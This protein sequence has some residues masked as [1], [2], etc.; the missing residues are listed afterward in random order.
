MLTP[1]IYEQVINKL[2]NSQLNTEENIVKTEQIDKEEA[3]KILSKYFSEILEKGL[4]NLKD[5]GGDLSKQIE[6]CNKLVNIIA[7]ET[8]ETFINDL[9]VDERAEQ[10]MAYMEKK[11]TIHALNGN[12]EITRPV[13]SIARSSL[14]T[15][16][17]KEPSMFSELK[18]E[19]LSC[20]RMDMLVSFIKWSGLR[21]IIDELKTFVQKGKLRIITTSYMGATDPKAIQELSELPNTEIK[22]SY[23]TKRTRLHAKTYVFYRNSGF[24]TAYIG[25]SNLS[26]A[27][28]S[29]G[30]EW[31]VKATQKDLPETIRKVEATFESYWN[32]SEFIE[33]NPKEKQRLETAIKEERGHLIMLLASILILSPTRIKVRFWTSS[34]LKETLKTIGEISSWQQPGQE[35]LLYRPLIIKIIFMKTSLNHADFCLLRIGKKY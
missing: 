13:T 27:A 3:S 11:N 16:A 2:I 21:L 24:T 25:S 8:E 5:S 30:L 15:G 10:L 1:G 35:K 26:N 6:L 28:I 7:N 31:N 33:Y 12:T 18:K 22:I 19:I 14:F 34:K 17:I 32:S 9:K 20:D 4:D 23:D 29:S